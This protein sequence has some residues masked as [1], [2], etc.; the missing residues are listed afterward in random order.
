[1]TTQLTAAFMTIGLI[2]A[3]NQL[4]VQDK[5]QSGQL[6]LIDSLTAY[7]DF[8][9]RL[10]DA[11][12]I[13]LGYDAPGVVQYEV[14][15]PFGVW[16]GEQILAHEDGDQPNTEQC[17]QWLRTTMYDFFRQGL[18]G[19]DGDNLRA[20]LVRALAAVDLVEVPA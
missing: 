7:A 1:M 14:D 13:A 12:Y 18:D 9:W 8:S 16:F 3:S 11:A 17:E 5:W 6:E 15:E 19:A 20:E 2:T 10:A 4:Q